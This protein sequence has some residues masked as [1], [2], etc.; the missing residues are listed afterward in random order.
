MPTSEPDTSSEQPSSNGNQHSNGAPSEG[1]Q[2]QPDLLGDLVNVAAENAKN[3]VV[4]ASS[5][6]EEKGARDTQIKEEGE[7]KK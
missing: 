6:S 1:P 2:Q 5:P 3:A 4:D 7:E